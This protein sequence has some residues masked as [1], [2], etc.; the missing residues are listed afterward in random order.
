MRR[1]LTLLLCLTLAAGQ[2]MAQTRTVKGKVTDEK[3][4]PVPNASVLVKGTTNGTKTNDDGSFTITVQA[5][6]KTLVVSS[7]G[8]A[9]Q[10]IAI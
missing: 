10:E 4:A 7:I 8:F 3:G 1:F 5:T 9:N 6:A 2:L